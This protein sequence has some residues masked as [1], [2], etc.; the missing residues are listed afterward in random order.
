M[1]FSL[2][3]GACKADY[4][5]ILNG[6]DL[7]VSEKVKAQKKDKGPNVLFKN[8]IQ[9][10]SLP[11][12][13]HHFLVFPSLP[14]STADWGLS[15]YQMVFWGHFRARLHQSLKKKGQQHEKGL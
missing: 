3:F 13:R 7:M 14:N 9:V 8:M 12:S 4:H 15:L 10:T 2:L 1:V 6:I 11:S 5:G